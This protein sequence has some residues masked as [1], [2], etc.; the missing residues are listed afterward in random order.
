LIER[1]PAFFV[2]AIAD[3][4]EFINNRQVLRAYQPGTNACV[5]ERV[6]ILRQHG[7][8]SDQALQSGW[9]FWI[10]RGGTFTD[11]LGRAM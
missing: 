4:P 5:S 1:R 3:G 8:M 10:D 7:A 6:Q 9:E 2:P 11:V